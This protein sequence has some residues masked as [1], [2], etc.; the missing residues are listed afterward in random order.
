MLLERV[1]NKSAS[2]NKGVF[3]I[4]NTESSKNSNSK[5]LNKNIA[6]N[7]KVGAKRINPINLNL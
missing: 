4:E 3:A 2:P 7:T 6:A 1:T 5:S